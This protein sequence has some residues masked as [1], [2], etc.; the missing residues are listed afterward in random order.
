MAEKPSD[1]PTQDYRGAGCMYGDRS[2]MTNP[3]FGDK[4]TKIGTQFENMLNPRTET[5]DNIICGV[6]I[7]CQ[8]SY[9]ND[10]SHAPSTTPTAPIHPCQTKIHELQE[11]LKRL[12]TKKS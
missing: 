5:G 1:R 3:Q 7:G 2:K 8:S 4:T 10:S 9:Y 12:S 6:E 11:K